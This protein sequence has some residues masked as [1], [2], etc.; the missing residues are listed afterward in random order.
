[1]LAVLPFFKHLG[2]DESFEDNVLYFIM[3]AMP[4]NTYL[5][6]VD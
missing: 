3:Q 6:Y 2:S 4:F 5:G 1:L